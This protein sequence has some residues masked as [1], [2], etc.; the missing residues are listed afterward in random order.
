VEPTRRI[1]IN[2]YNLDM[3]NWE[4]KLALECFMRGISGY[5]WN[6]H[7]PVENPAFY[8][9]Y[10]E[11]FGEDEERRLLVKKEVV[12]GTKTIPEVPG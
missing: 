12:N 9:R 3:G 7:I 6:W 1:L 5:A 11:T 2:K 4:D 10:Q 8:K